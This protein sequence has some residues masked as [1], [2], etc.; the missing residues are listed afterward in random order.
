MRLN[1][2]RNAVAKAVA[3]LAAC[4]GAFAGAPRMLRAQ[5]QASDSVVYRVMPSSRFEVKT[6]TAGVFG[7]AGHNHVVRAHAFDGWVVYYP[8]DQAA[9]RVELTVP[10]ESLVV[11]TPADTAEIRQV[12]EAMRTQV[13]HV[14]QYPLI[15]F[16]ARGSAPTAKGMRLQGEMTLVGQTR[17]VHMDAM[18]HVTGDTLRASGGFS[19]KQ[20]DFGIKPYRGGPGGTVKVADQVT[21]VFDVIAVRDPTPVPVQAVVPNARER[22]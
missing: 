18:L 10:A 13:L 8:A 14:T 19:V 2:G 9:S 17:P 6:G 11:Q 1:R 5:A 22:W 7:F 15:R 20:T 12:T 16:A 21:F 4:T 3:Y